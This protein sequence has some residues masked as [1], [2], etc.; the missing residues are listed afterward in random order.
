[1]PIDEA[2]FEKEKPV[3]AKSLAAQQSEAVFDSWF[4]QQKKVA[5]IH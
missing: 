2:D 3:L 1:L 5:N 4:K